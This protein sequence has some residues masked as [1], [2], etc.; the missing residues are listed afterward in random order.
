MLC[1]VGSG[2]VYT[3]F[4]RGRHWVPGV[5]IYG[6]LS[7][8]KVIVD[9]ERVNRENDGESFMEFGGR[10]VGRRLS[11]GDDVDRL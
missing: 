4:G 10:V 7:G 8:H 3:T 5:L 9:G 2:G 6:L 1:G 11:E